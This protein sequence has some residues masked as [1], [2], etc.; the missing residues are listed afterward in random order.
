MNCFRNSYG[1]TIRQHQVAVLDPAISH[2][3][4]RGAVEEDTR[5][6][7]IEGSGIAQARIVFAR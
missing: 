1:N 3:I 2:L 4:P 6:G 5:L 7:H